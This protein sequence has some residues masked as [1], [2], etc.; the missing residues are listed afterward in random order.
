[1]PYFSEGSFSFFIA[2]GAYDF[3][4]IRYANNVQITTANEL[5]VQ[6]VIEEIMKSSLRK[7]IWS[8]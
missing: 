3:Q 8:L 6:S 7:F 5:L 4:S 2:C 1:M